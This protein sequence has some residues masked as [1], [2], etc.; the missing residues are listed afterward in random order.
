MLKFGTGLSKLVQ[1][2]AVNG[3]VCLDLAPSDIAIC[4]PASS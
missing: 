1:A 4:R 3:L 2:K